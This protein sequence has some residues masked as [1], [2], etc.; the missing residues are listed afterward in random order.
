M[1]EKA[2]RRPRIFTMG[3]SDHSIEAFLDILERSSVR[4]VADVRS[5]PASARY[6][7]FE[8]HALAAEL[9]KRGLAYRWFRGLGGRRPDCPDQEKH[10]AL[11]EN[12]D[13]AYACAMNTRE[14]HRDCEEIIGLAA[15]TVATVLCAERDP[16]SCHR[17]LLADKLAAMGARVVHILGPDDA[18]EHV[19]HPALE[20][21]DSGALVYRKKQLS[22]I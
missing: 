17:M 8:R 11:I 19:R 5:N 6:P 4:L 15:S 21:E 14:F 10:D 7:W 9:E 1:T 13:R 12:E 2:I 3:H 22:L 18:V 16:E 20:I